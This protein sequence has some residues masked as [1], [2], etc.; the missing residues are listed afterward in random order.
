ML[1]GLCL[2]RAE[3]LAPGRRSNAAAPVA[4]RGPPLP[5]L[6]SG[7]TYCYYLADFKA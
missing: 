5:P 6:E 4:H 7:L 2:E 3:A 1:S